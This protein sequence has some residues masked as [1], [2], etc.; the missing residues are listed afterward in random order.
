MPGIPLAAIGAGL[1]QFANYMQQERSNRE[2]QQML[3]ITL[4]KYQQE[5]KDRQDQQQAA[6][7]RWGLSSGGGDA[8][9][10]GQEGGGVG[11]P[12]P[13]AGG[14]VDASGGDPLSLISKYESGGRNIKNP[15]SSASGPWQFINSTWREMAPKEGVD[16]TQYPTAMSAPVEVQKRVAQR[17]YNERGYSPWAPYNPRLAAALKAPGVGGAI[18]QAGVG[19]MQPEFTPAPPPPIMGASSQT[20]DVNNATND[21]AYAQVQAAEKGPW[22]QWR[23]AVDAQELADPSGTRFLP[24]GGG[25]PAVT[26]TPGGTNGIVPARAPRG[27]SYDTPLSPAE[28]TA[29]R[30]WKQRY[31]PQDSGA[32]YDLRGA[33]KAG[34]TPDPQTGHW[35]DTF[36]KPNH[37]TFS[38]QS[39]YATGADAARAGS[40]QGETY[41]PPREQ[42]MAQAG[43]QTATDA[44]PLTA[45]PADL[46][47]RLNKI[48]PPEV[49]GRM[50]EGALKAKIDQ[51]M[52]GASPIVKLQAL[53]DQMKRLAPEE[54]HRFQLK[55]K[56]YESELTAETRQWEQDQEERKHLRGRA[57]KKQDEETAPGPLIQRGDQTWVVNPRKRTAAPV[58]VEGTGE[59]LTDAQKMGSG[60]AGSLSADRARELVARTKIFDDEYRA[61]N[62]N[63]TAAELNS[64]HSRNRLKAEHELASAK[65]SET[66]STLANIAMRKL[67][68]EHPEWDGKDLLRESSKIIAQQATDRNFAGGS[69]ATQMRSLNTVADHL[70]LMKEY[71]DALR[72]GSMPFTDIPRLNQ[73]I[74]AAAVNLGRPE[75]TNFNVARDIMADEVVRLLTSTGGTEADRAG[76]QSRLAAAMSE[77]QQTGSLTAFERFTAGR[78][79]GLEQGYARNDPERVKD[80]RDNM[81]TPE[82]REI[83]ARHGTGAGDAAPASA[84]TAG[85]IPAEAV[86]MLHNDKSPDA[87]QKFDA[88]FG[89]GAA[90]KALGGG[91]PRATPGA[92]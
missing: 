10:V 66:R 49:N 37:P 12:A 91:V 47:Q 30:A 23:G 62:P 59:P 24:R 35:P 65:T 13:S 54:Q 34:L 11:V 45:P 9:P 48:I 51:L 90:A 32:D 81:L 6:A 53:E 77:Y 56:Q 2:R 28:E 33:F 21:A 22:R 50:S 72:T 43:G 71:S 79:K 40:W 76:M 63:A 69:G 39:R 26:S 19:A 80:F 52:P 60:G 5:Q 38:D 15:T 14:Q 3:A 7:L 74:Q 58:T 82:G 55:L 27:Q 83:F 29:F 17:L 68:D 36:K 70:K 25:T 8:K 42:Q 4:A 1:G 85:A 44:A 88:I 67:R 61:A 75:V 46:R 31:A 18:G 20:S 89:A 78:F 57:E 87:Q 92:M 84:A 41:T 16:I 86:E 73:I 64:E